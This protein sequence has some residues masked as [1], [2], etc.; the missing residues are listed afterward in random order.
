[1]YVFSL[2]C[3][4][5]AMVAN[6]FPSRMYTFQYE[7]CRETDPF[8]KRQ[9]RIH[10]LSRSPIPIW[11]LV[12]YMF[13]VLDHLFP[14][15][16]IFLRMDTFQ[17]MKSPQRDRSVHETTTSCIFKMSRLE[18]QYRFCLLVQYLFEVLDHLSL[19]LFLWYSKP[20]TDKQPSILQK[21]GKLIRSLN[22]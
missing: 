3:M 2:G 7:I 15:L 14:L 12:Q 22:L 20:T 11:L 16:L 13:L 21:H 5:T 9:P 10:F 19:L 1:M 17:H 6:R 8:T 18:V 4:F